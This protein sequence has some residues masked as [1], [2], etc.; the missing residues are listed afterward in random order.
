MTGIEYI[1]AANVGKSSNM[2]AN[3]GMAMTSREIIL[4]PL[5]LMAEKNH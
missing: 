3:H 4:S 2:Y 5:L 1:A